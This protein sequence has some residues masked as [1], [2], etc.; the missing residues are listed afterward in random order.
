MR[1]LER[2]A[3]IYGV[4]AVY[5]DDRRRRRRCSSE[6]LLAVLQALGAPISEVEEASDAL[7]ACHRRSWERWVQPVHVAWGGRPPAIRLRLPEPEL[8]GRLEAVLEAEEG[9]GEPPR[10]RCVE[11]ARLRSLSAVEVDGRRYVEKQLALPG[12]LPPGYHRLSLEAGGRRAESWIISAPV[13]ASLP[14]AFRRGWGAFLPLHALRSR[15]AWGIGDLTGLENLARWVGEQGGRVVGTLPIL[16][17]FLDE[18]FEISPYAP[19]SRL[20]WN[21]IFIDVEA[22]PEFAECE[23]AWHRVRGPRFKRWLRESNGSETVDYRS[24]MRRKR[25]I[26]EELSRFVASASPGREAALCRFLRER[27]EVVDYARFRAVGERLRTPWQEWPQSLREG[28]IRRRDFDPDSER[29]HCYVQW[30]AHEQVEALRR[31]TEALG[32]GLYFDLPLGVH[33]SSY[34]VHRYRE[35]F[36]Q[37]ASAGAPPDSF[38]TRGQNW[39]FPPFHPERIR[40]QRY[41]YFIAALRHQLRSA[42][43]LRIDC[44]SKPDASGA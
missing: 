12:G 42:R 9:N 36:V 11:L 17:G 29:Y 32:V 24:V 3:S 38:F 8:C 23:A 31:R 10:R 25:E 14:S 18:P 19:A 15:H 28:S 4:Q 34:D 2:L 44:V 27:P 43:V 21:E 26:L 33:R 6:S 30:V 13:R 1:D 22:I 37:D 5:D 16:A 35:V 20:F 7:S 41:H 40:E 39:G